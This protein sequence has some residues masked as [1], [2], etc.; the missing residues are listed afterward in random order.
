MKFSAIVS[1]M[2]VAVG[3][4][5]CVERKM[6]ITT[7]PADAVVQ[8]SD[9]EIGRSPV[10]RTFTWY[11]DYDIII[12]KE[13]YKTLKTHANLTRPWYEVPPLD[14]FSAIAPWTYHD[15]RYL[16]FKLD[17]LQ[18]PDDDELIRRAGEMEQRNLQPVGD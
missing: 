12:R 14:F 6:L 13:G 11:G 18:L 2:I 9:V 4:T 5:G 7:E 16:H 10:E 8:V 15:R 17:K 1:G 3:L